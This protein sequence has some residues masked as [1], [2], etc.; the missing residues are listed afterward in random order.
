MNLL[1]AGASGFLLKDA[2]AAVLAA[3][4]V[5]GVLWPEA[6]AGGT[7]SVAGEAV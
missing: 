3:R 5:L 2:D 1:R 7:A 4:P 6:Y